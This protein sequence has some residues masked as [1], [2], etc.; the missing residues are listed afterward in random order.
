MKHI[1]IPLSLIFMISCSTGGSGDTTAQLS[2]YKKQVNE[3][4]QRI[5]ELESTLGEEAVDGNEESVVAVEVKPIIPV[6][7]SRYFEVIGKMEAVQDAYISPEI[8]GQIKQILVRRGARVEAGDLLLKLNTD[9]TEKSIAEVRTSL[10]LA[11]K[12]F[13]K[14]EELWSQNIG[15]EIQ[16]LEAKN[17]KEAL[18]A[19][20]ATLVKQLEMAH[21]R[22][23]FTGIVDQVLIKQGELAAPGS[24]LLRLVN[25]KQMRVSA[26]VSEAYLTNVSQGEEVELQFPTYPD[27]II[28]RPIS[29]LGEVIDDQ[30]RTFT[31]EV[32]LENPEQK[33]KPN[34]LTTVRIEDFSAGNA[35]VVPSVVLKEDFRGTFLFAARGTGQGH[36][37]EKV[38]VERGITVQD[39]TMITNGILPN[40]LVI[41][42][43]YHLVSDGTP[44]R[45]TNP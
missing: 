17:S 13:E 44:V 45:I 39:Q 29:R 6:P 11:T 8:N 36:S 28:K 7:F 4:N 10:E 31:L 33:L 24:R 16:F 19:R 27:L 12:L 30:T 38:Y 1:I 2:R 37:A 5:A 3:L 42:K 14:Q 32:E 23:P 22:A 41:V 15:S 18:E 34:M 26:Q 40:D 21:I 9:V 43:G 20:M 35:L 25:L